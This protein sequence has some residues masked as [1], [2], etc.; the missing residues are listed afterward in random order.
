[1]HRE[2]EFKP[3]LENKPEE[4][5]KEEQKKEEEKKQKHSKRKANIPY[6]NT[7][8]EKQI[9]EPFT[10]ENHSQLL[11]RFSSEDLLDQENYT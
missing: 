7:E 9:F 5:K 4:K 8:L 2:S 3:L 6:V 10:Q 1:M 11:D